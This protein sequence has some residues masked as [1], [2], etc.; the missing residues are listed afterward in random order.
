MVAARVARSK[1]AFTIAE[2][3]ILPSAVDMCREL[4]GDAAATKIQS[5]PMTR[6]LDKLLTWAMTL[7][8]NSWNE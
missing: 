5:F 7:N 6:F 3:L 1:K 4:L 2:E 8:A